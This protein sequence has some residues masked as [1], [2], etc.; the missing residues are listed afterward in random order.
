MEPKPNAFFTDSLWHR[1][2]LKF[3][4]RYLKKYKPEVIGKS[5]LLITSVEYSNKLIYDAILRDKPFMFGRFGSVELSTVTNYTGIKKPCRNYYKLVRGE[6]QPWWWLRG[7]RKTMYENTGFFNPTPDN[8]SRF[9]E[10]ILEDMK[11]L[12][13]LAS[14]SAEEEYFRHLFPKAKRVSFNSTEPFFCIYPWTHALAGKKVLVVHPMTDSIRKQWDIREKI[15]PDGMM[16]EFELKTLKAV[17]TIA[18]EKSQF[19]SWFDALGFMKEEINKI[20][21]DVCIIGCGAYGFPLAAHVKRMGKK[22]L[23]FGGVTQ[24]FFG[25]RGKRWE[26]DPHF[27]FT[28]FMNEHWI[29]PGKSETPG[30]AGI[31]EGGCYW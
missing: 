21:F 24:L 13:I 3:R 6:I 8:L 22:A 27:P 20:E 26:N 25:I 19:A 31:V 1:I 9:A 14:L 11:E 10:L 18:G 5:K 16:P 15:W 29:R 7:I 28:N 23:H 2:V 4:E 12:D 30:N 17:Q